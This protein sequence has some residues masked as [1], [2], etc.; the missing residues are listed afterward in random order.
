MQK[1]APQNRIS[2]KKRPPRVNDALACL[3]TELRAYHR[4]CELS[5]L[6]ITLFESIVRGYLLS[7]RRQAF[8]REELRAEIDDLLLAILRWRHSLSIYARTPIL[9]ILLC[10]PH[11]LSTRPVNNDSSL[12][13]VKLPYRPPRMSLVTISCK[14]LSLFFIEQPLPFSIESFHTSLHASLSSLSANFTVTNTTRNKFNTL[15][16]F[17]IKSTHRKAG[18]NRGAAPTV[19]A[20]IL[21][22]RLWACTRQ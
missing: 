3:A 14:H 20:I 12:I 13:E 19:V 6:M 8:R 7:W 4:Y 10:Q 15:C 22:P 21:P 9:Y 16:Y 1:N 17:Y 2:K 18:G 5:S 11:E